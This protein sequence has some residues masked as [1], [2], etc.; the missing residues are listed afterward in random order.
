M[1]QYQALAKTSQHQADQA[2]QGA[3][4][5]K[6]L[7]VNDVICDNFLQQS[8]LHPGNFA[9]IATL[10]L[11]GDYLSD[12]LAAQV[13]GIGIAPGANINYQTGQA[14]FEATHGTAPQ[15]AGQN[16]MNPTSLLLS[17]AMMFDYLGW[18][19][20]GD[21]IRQGIA[22][23]IASQHVTADL[24]TSTATNVLSTSSFG[25]YLVSHL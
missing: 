11:N 18:E 16:K 1:A 13:G 9:V 12:A 25:N 14:L 21:L 10:N 17:G 15:F 4:A 20:V 7:I 24:A 6:K 3:R 2:L 23:A 19:A 5:Q 22:Q 8:L